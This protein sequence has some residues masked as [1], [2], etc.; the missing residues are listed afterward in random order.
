MLSGLFPSLYLSVL[1]MS[2]F[3]EGELTRS[4]ALCVVAVISVDKLGCED[5][6]TLVSSL[7]GSMMILLLT[8]FVD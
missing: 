4:S 1:A 2:L 7:D 6:R 3:L 8:W 5:R